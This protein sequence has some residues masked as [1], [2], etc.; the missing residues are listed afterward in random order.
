MRRQVERVQHENVS[1]ADQLEQM[2]ADLHRLQQE[3]RAA[4]QE[5]EHAQ[6]DREAA[7]D[8]RDKALATHRPPTDSNDSEQKMRGLEEELRRI[9]ELMAQERTAREDSER[10]TAALQAELGRERTQRSSEKELLAQLQARLTQMEGE[11][12]ALTDQ[13]ATKDADLDQVNLSF[14]ILSRS[15]TSVEK[16]DEYCLL[17]GRRSIF[18]RSRVIVTRSLQSSQQH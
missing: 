9:L 1:L 12:A 13:V 15:I 11:T 7:L 5:A 6:K 18:L 3:L 17:L 8:A 14:L 2:Q 4:V 10:N 16:H